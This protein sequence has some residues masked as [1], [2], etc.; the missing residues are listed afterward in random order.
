M[1]SLTLGF[2][3]GSDGKESACMQCRRPGFNPRVGEI[4][5]RREWQPTPVSLPGEF[6]GLE[7]SGR[8]Q[9]LGLQRVRHD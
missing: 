6:H 1:I 4:S 9:S 7:E 2:P 5:W 8:L 3:G